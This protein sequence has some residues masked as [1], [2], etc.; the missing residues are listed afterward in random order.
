MKRINTN[1][2]EGLDGDV[3][4]RLFADIRG[5]I[6]AHG[7]FK[8][9]AISADLSVAT[10]SKLAYGDTGSPHMRTVVRIMNALGKSDPIV[11][12]FRAEKPVSTVQ[13]FA[14]KLKTTEGR[15]KRKNEL[16]LKIHPHRATRIARR[17]ASLH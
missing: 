13:A 6:W 14:R 3:W 1:R 5:H 4:E 8:K 12:A 2:S 16:H 11:K 7:D 17:G 10:V 9:L 15:Q